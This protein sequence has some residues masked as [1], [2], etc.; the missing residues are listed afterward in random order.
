MDNIPRYEFYAI[1]VRIMMYLNL[2][3]K[4]TA[5][6]IN[7]ELR[8]AIERCRK[9]ARKAETATER[10][11]L[12]HAAI[13][14]GR[15]IEYGFPERVIREARMDP[16]GIIGMTLKYGAP[17]AKRRILAQKRAQIRSRSRSGHR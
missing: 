10:N 14:Y 2:K 8:E 5:E 15:L 7:E 3:G 17:E 13:G 1:F 11:K 16:Y 12:K 6:A 9:L 4:F